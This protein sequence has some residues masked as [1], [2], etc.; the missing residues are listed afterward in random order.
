MALINIAQQLKPLEL[1][2]LLLFIPE[3]FDCFIYAVELESLEYNRIL[4]DEIFL[5]QIS[6][7][8]FQNIIAI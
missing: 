5:N 6:G 4:Q 7:N 8:F 2:K 3:G 1:N